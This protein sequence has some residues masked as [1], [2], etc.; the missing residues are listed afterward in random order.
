MC[1]VFYLGSTK[2]KNLNEPN[3]ISGVSKVADAGVNDRIRVG[4]AQLAWGSRPT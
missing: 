3:S 2:V 1:L 4:G